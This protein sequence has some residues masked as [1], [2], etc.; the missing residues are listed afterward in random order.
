MDWIDL[1]LDRD[2]WR[3]VVNTAINPRIH[4][5]AGNLLSSCGPLGFSGRTLLH[6]VS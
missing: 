2:K 5:N 6:G 3:A 1:A 4:Q